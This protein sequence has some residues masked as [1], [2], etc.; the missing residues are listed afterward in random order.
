ME[1][2]YPLRRCTGRI[3]GKMFYPNDTRKNIGKTLPILSNVSTGTIR[4]I[5]Y[6]VYNSPRTGEYCLTKN[7]F[8]L[9]SG[10][11]LSK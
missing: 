8:V 10:D 11:K 1:K 4:I 5:R 2:K 3:E 9:L 6:S 7:V